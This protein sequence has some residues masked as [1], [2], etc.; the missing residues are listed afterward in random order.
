VGPPW[1]AG[2]PPEPPAPARCATLFAGAARSDLPPRAALAAL[3]ATPALIIGWDGDPAHPLS[4]A[5]ELHGLLPCSRLVVLSC[6][7]DYRSI[8]ARIA[9]FATLANNNTV[10]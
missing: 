7:D 1:L 2:A 3:A 9:R 10:A 8:G 4:C 5:Q 6:A